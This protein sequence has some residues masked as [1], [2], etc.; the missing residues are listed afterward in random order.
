MKIALVTKVRFFPVTVRKCKRMI[1]IS[2]PCAAM[3]NTSNKTRLNKNK[4]FNVKL[5]PAK[6]AAKM[7]IQL[8]ILQMW[9]VGT[10]NIFKGLLCVCA[11][12]LCGDFQI[13][14]SSPVCVWALW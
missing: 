6:M 12:V 11:C 2:A 7:H 14:V 8:R 13:F 1:P 10:L 5:S 9:C 4:Y 3:M